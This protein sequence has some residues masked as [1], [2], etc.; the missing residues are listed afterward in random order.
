MSM[1]DPDTDKAFYW[2]SARTYNALLICRKLSQISLRI[3]DFKRPVEKI[4]L[5]D[6]IFHQRS[7][8]MNVFN[9]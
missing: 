2:V 6:I 7:D 1:K 9:L 8:W 3:N 5:N 4:N